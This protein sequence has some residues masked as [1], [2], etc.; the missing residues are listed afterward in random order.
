MSAVPAQDK[1]ITS[2]NELETKAFI[3]T[4]G[5]IISNG[6]LGK[7]AGVAAIAVLVLLL[8]AIL[9][10]VTQSKLHVGGLAPQYTKPLPAAQ[11]RLWWQ[12]ESDGLHT[13]SVFASPEIHASPISQAAKPGPTVSGSMRSVAADPHRTGPAPALDVGNPAAK[14]PAIPLLEGDALG[15][16]SPPS[17]ENA[18]AAPKDQSNVQLRVAMLARSVIDNGSNSASH[19]P[20]E[21]K[22]GTMI[23]AALITAID[24]DLPGL[25]IAQVRQNTYDSLTGRF[26]LI[27]QGARIVGTYDSRISYGQDRLLVTWTRLIYP[28]GVSLDLRALAGADSAGRSGFDAQVTNHARKLFRGALLLSV[29]GAGAQLSQPQQSAINGSAPSV[30]QIIAGNVGNQIANAS[31]QLTQRQL[32]VAPNLRVPA[33]YQFNVLIDHDIECF[34]AYPEN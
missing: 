23:P 8:A 6:R 16:P 25:L 15:A 32:N 2:P 12:N 31:T 19:S 14:I 26:L 4:R 1:T 30:G 3:R 9:Y 34:R 29:I 21:L 27:P 10:G 18:V 22:A 17:Q 28:D 13:A 24:S 5:R 33:G 11:T 20:F 7:K